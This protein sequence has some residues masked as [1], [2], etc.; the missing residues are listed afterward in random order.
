MK[1]KGKKTEKERVKGFQVLEEECIWMKAGIVNFR[2]CDNAYDCYNCPFDLGMR[3]AMVLE[4]SEGKRAE[5]PA[6]VDYLQQ[7]YHG[8]SR[9]C[10]HALTG[11]IDAPKICP[12]NYE[13]YHCPYDQIL[14]DMDLDHTF[15]APHYQ[16]VSGYRM[17]EGYYYHMGHSWVRFEHGGR[18][19]VGFDDFF[20]KLFGAVDQ[21]DLPPLGA[22]ISQHEVGWTFRRD[23][24]K[25]TV[26]SPVTGK[27]LATN[28]RCLDHPEIANANPYQAGWL[29][30]V[31][32]KFPKRDLKGLYFGEEGFRWLEMENRNLMSFLGPEY[33]HLASTGGEV[34]NDIYG[35]IQESFLD[36]GW[37]RLIQTF[38]RTEAI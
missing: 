5:R 24:H 23:D 6:W 14:D 3:Q 22:E 13:C 18:V 21:L 7:R 34:I 28:H 15:P 36:P 1:E 19:R 12:H 29:F 35:T 8:A 33:E 31:E 17:A 26:L 25:G 30:M 32:P 16:M 38:L 9:P 20:A 27:V 10:R 4:P 2:L 37:N 11:R